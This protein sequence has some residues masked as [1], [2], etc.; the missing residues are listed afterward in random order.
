MVNLLIL[1]LASISIVLIGLAITS[2]IIFLKMK[3][4]KHKTDY[5][6]LFI[7]G[8]IWIITSVVMKRYIISVIGIIIA[9][10]GLTQKKNWKKNQTKWK[11]MKSHEEKNHLMLMLILLAV[12]IIGGS[13]WWINRLIN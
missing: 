11:K 3:S 4:N 2:I 10:A 8:I 6:A 1:G 12:L 13:I 9:G 5:F 7:F